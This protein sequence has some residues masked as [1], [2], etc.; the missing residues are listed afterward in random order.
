MIADNSTHLDFVVGTVI[1]IKGRIANIRMF[2][3]SNQLYHF[4]N[5]QRYSGASIGSFVGIKR[6]KYII[7]AKIEKE[8]AYDR[9]NNNK[10]QEFEKDRFVREIEVKILGSLYKEEYEAGLGV[11]PQL[12]NDV[13]LLSEKQKTLVIQTKEPDSPDS[14]SVPEDELG[15]SR[16]PTLSIGKT[17]PDNIEYN[18]PWY[19]LFNSHIAI[20][21]NTGS[22]KSNTLAKLYHELFEL[23][24]KD[25]K[26]NFEKSQFLIIDF[27][28]EYIGKETI[29]NNKKI[30]SLSTQDQESYRSNEAIITDKLNIPEKEFWDIELLAI[31]FGATEQTQRPFLS[32]VLD[33]Y[34]KNDIDEK[35]NLSRYLSQAFAHV[36]SVSNKESLDLFKRVLELLNIDNHNVSDWI[37]NTMVN[38]SNDN[39]Y[40]ETDLEGWNIHQKSGVKD[41]YYWNSTEEKLEIEKQNVQSKID[42]LGVKELSPLKSL[43]IS[44]LLQLIYELRYNMAQYD[45]IAP[46]LA[47]IGSRTEDFDNIISVSKNNKPMF[48]NGVT[49]VS[50]KDVNIDMKMLLPLLIAK[51]SY[52]EHKEYKDSD[53]YFNLII[54]EAHNILSDSSK[55]ESEKWKD[56]RLETFE[57][58]I[59]EGRKFSYFLTISSQRP[60]DISATIV[61]QVHNYFIHRLV[62][63]HDLKLLDSTMSSLDLVSKS[64]IPNLAPGQAILTGVLFDLPI[65]IKV[66][67]LK[68]KRAPKS[69]TISLLKTWL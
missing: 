59:K 69:E 5:G 68:E 6:N 63:D 9:H 67:Q 50:L 4:Y 23:T 55:R 60:S 57:E 54:D 46:L 58:I 15:A 56:Y 24:Y 45:H 3:N 36:Y 18:I 44:S 31:L 33:Y 11:F 66:D 25:S 65:T 37:A 53:R 20:F 17:W 2:E 16:V 48:T 19:Y 14:P 43:Y 61:S 8:Y 64:N 42:N 22:G 52:K 49:V 39:F 13:I 29:T 41:R 28:G 35:F 30:L 21:G 10:V 47:R 62:N 38:T 34:F 40:S 7:I 1:E 32:R 26:L 51:I 27:N 12:F